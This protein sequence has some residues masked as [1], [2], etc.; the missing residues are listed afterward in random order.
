MVE[1]SAE[2]SGEF[3][4]VTFRNAIRIKGQCQALDVLGHSNKNG[5]SHAAEQEFP[6]NSFFKR[7]RS[8]PTGILGMLSLG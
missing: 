7:A 1:I 5:P 4:F 8:S 2:H 3:D 6:S